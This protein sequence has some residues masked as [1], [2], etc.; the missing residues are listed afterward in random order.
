MDD[1]IKVIVISN[2]IIIVENL[3]NSNT[4]SISNTKKPQSI[5]N[6]NS[7]SDLRNRSISNS[8]RQNVIEPSLDGDCGCA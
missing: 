6:C 5:S 3:S 8:N 1:K 4:C 2:G 7:N